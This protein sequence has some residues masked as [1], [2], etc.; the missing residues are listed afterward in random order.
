[1]APEQEPA[2]RSQRVLAVGAA[3]LIAAATAIAFGRVFVGHGATWRLLA[4]A[5]ASV[6]IAALFERRSLLLATVVS[7]VCLVLVLGW[8]VFP[9]ATWF[10]VPTEQ[11]LRAIGD[12]LR[13]V[14]E[15][16]RVQVAPT[17]PVAPLLLAAV[18]AVWTA[19]FSA[20]ALAVRAGSPL[21]AALPPV[22]LVGFADTVMQDGARPIYAILLL[23][24]IL[25]VVFVDGLRRIRQ[26]G[27][28]WGARRGTPTAASHG[29]RRV[30]VLAVAVAVLA[31]GILPGFRSGALVD[32]STA[33]GS[34]VHLDPF[35]SISA[36]LQQ[37]TPIDLFRV[38]SLDGSGR[39][40]PAYWRLY[41]LD[42]FDGNTWRSSDPDA[43]RGLVLQSPADLGVTAPPDATSIDQRYHVLTDLSDRWLPLAYP[44]EHIDAPFKGI[45]YDQELTA[46]MAPD[47]VGD[48]LEYTA[49]SFVLSPTPE[50]LDAVSFAGSAPRRDTFVPANVPPEVLRIARSWTEGETT[51]YRKVLAIQQHFLA[52]GAFHYSV[53][54]RPRSDANALVDFL[55]RIRT[56]FCQQFATAMAV[57][58]RELGIPA[59]VAVGFR[60]GSQSGGTFT[61]S[62]QDAHSWVEVEFPGYGWLTFDPTPGGWNSPL[63]TP[64]SYL[65]PGTTP[66]CESGSQGCN[67]KKNETINPGKDKGL[68]AD[69]IKGFEYSLGPQSAPGHP[70]SHGG[71]TS[72]I[73][74]G[75][76]VPYR[77]LLEGLLGLLGLLLIAAPIVKTVLRRR[78]LRGARD[79]R[80]M[81]LRAYRLFESEAADLGLGRREAETIAE[82]RARLIDTVR[83]RDGHV[84]RLS[85]AA[86]AAAYSSE[87]ASLQEAGQAL[88]DAKVAIH[89]MRVDAG[90]VRRARGFYR[91]GL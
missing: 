40:L 85:R 3:A 57:L 21:L 73:S 88:S 8:L 23:G 16:A 51:P 36:E 58:V 43:Q 2:A 4:T 74:T 89:D 25:L 48:G 50:Q 33:G 45:R 54:V 31:P 63:A 83:F 75:Y 81:V 30:A 64:G 86:S 62:T 6:G 79:S 69:K 80:A 56:G 28:V 60:P 15:Q 13:Q 35:V 34:H 82:H 53:Q 24:A 10:G 70:T 20:H 7:G 52:P 61:V 90:W 42:A 39:P 32:F 72:T 41:A 91:P 12:A 17:P 47:A 44:P 14:G 59:R 77:L 76:S 11:T 29:A 38:T 37:R 67:P 55:T 49:T 26:W 71:G 5:V 87:P 84:D 27:P 18:T 65:N 19:A 1:M 9:H 78:M 66:S 68:F 46:V 22:A